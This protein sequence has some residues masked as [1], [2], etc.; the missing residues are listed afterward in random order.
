MYIKKLTI[1]LFMLLALSACSDV[2]EALGI[3]DTPEVPS[4]GVV[5]TLKLPT[6]TKHSIS[7]RADGGETLNTLAVLCYDSSGT[8]LGMTK[9]SGSDI[10]ATDAANGI[11]SAKVKVLPETSSIHVVTNTDVSDADAKDANGNVNL[12]NAMRSGEISTS[13][14]IC[15]GSISV[16][17]LLDGS[18]QLSLLRMFAKVSVTSSVNSTEN[19]FEVT[20]FKLYNTANSG[21][22]AS[23]SLSGVAA[24]SVGCTTSTADFVTGEVPCYETP[25]KNAYIIIRGKYNGGSESYYKVMFLPNDATANDNQMALLRNHHYQIKIVGVNHDGWA[26]ENLA[27]TNDCENRI[28]TEIIDDNPPIVDMMACRDYELGVCGEQTVLGK[29]KTAKVTF[30]T[31]KPD[32][33]YDVAC[34]AN[35]ATV[36]KTPVETVTLPQTDGASSKLSS[37]GKLYTLEVKLTENFNSEARHAKLTVTSGDLSLDIVVTQLGYD[38][39]TDENRKVLICG[40]NGVADRTDYFKWMDSSL[41]GILPSENQGLVRNDG[42]HFFVG[43]NS[44]YYLIPKLSGDQLTCKDSRVKVDENSVSGYYKVTLADNSAESNNSNN[45]N[46]WVNKDALSIITITNSNNQI[47]ITYPVYHVGLF[48]KLSGKAAEDYQMGTKKSSGW[49]YYEV[50]DVKGANNKTYHVLDRNLGS[51]S[52][53]YYSP[54][55]TDLRADSVARG[56]YFK[57]S[58]VENSTDAKTNNDVVD[59]LAI[60]YFKVCSQSFLQDIVDCGSLQVVEKNTAYGEKYNCIQIQTTGNSQHAYVYIPMSGYYESQQLR[61]PYHANLWSSSRLAGYQGFSNTSPEYG[62]WYVYLDVYG[63]QKDLSNFRFVSGSSGENTGRY[64]GLPVRLAV[65]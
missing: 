45:Y 42:L 17:D 27:R 23:A 41:Q 10:T 30:V 1:W 15:W 14:P 62:F 39:R 65:E 20:G 61:N 4:E 3:D 8:Y 25:A 7:T 51:P 54:A 44:V 64:R 60:G 21:T 48:S 18:A 12:Y 53:A 13:A 59:A 58:V 28:K 37:V 5:L 35:W 47:S 36:E 11:Y 56:G 38:F 9:L 16:S 52:D 33:T 46:L 43:N 22:I 26:T 24:P 6:F 34:D 19:K 63:K 55:T 40:L 49:Y 50:V 2:K 31:T 32:F 57:V 29:D